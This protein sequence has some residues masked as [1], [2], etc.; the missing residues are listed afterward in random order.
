VGGAKS[1]RDGHRQVPAVDS[2]LSIGGRLQIW[3]V[4]DGGYGSKAAAPGE[5]G[6]LP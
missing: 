1:R 2:V 6:R 5:G 4:S 3:E